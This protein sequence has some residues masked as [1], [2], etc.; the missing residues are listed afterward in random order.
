MSTIMKGLADNALA[1]LQDRYPDAEVVVSLID[2][3]YLPTSD[4]TAIK[5]VA[6]INGEVVPGMGASVGKAVQK[7]SERYDKSKM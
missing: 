7:L 1:D 3:H 5:V 4:V 2:T 6:V